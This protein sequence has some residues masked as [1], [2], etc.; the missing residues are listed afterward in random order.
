MSDYSSRVSAIPSIR[1]HILQLQRNIAKENNIV[2]EGRDITSHVLTDAKYKFFVTASAE[3]RAER[4]YMENLSK[5]I[6]CDYDEILN[7][8]KQRDYRDTTRK[9]CPLIV[10]D[11]AIVV[12]TSNLTVQDAV[13]KILSYIKEYECYTISY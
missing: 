8:L 6:A 12:D 1:Q 3:V 10:V 4:R 13:N 9:V 11:D 7:D 5:G 2:M